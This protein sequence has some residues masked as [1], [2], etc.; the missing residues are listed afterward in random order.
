MKYWL[1]EYLDGS[2]WKVAG[3]TK[4]GDGFK[5]NVE[6][7]YASE[8]GKQTNTTIEP[9]VTLTSDT[10][11]AKFRITAVANN[12]SESGNP[13]TLIDASGALRFAGE[14]CNEKTPHYSVKEHP[15][16]D[17]VE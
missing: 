4:D 12:N 8:S 6:L 1:V 2:E 3:T 13:V 15:I 14:D 7:F 16:I 9:T 10:P 5:Y 17:V 11:C